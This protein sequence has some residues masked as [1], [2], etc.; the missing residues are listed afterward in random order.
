MAPLYYAAKFDPFLGLRPQALHPGAIQGKEGIKFCHLA[1]L[2][3]GGGRPRGD[4]PAARRPRH[5][6]LRHDHAPRRPQLQGSADARG[7][8]SAGLWR[9]AAA[10]ENLGCIAVEHG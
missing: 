5:H 3:Q 4:P 7:V 8:G 10:G 6:P 1:T 2:R 9:L